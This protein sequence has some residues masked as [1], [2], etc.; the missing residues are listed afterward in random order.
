[1]KHS[2]I[3]VGSLKRATPT[4]ENVVNYVKSYKRFIDRDMKTVIQNTTNN[5]GALAL[6][7]Y[8]EALFVH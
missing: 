3:K 4:L 1:M 5:L 8:T 6:S 7:A 2:I